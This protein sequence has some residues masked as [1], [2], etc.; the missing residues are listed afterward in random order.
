MNA[1][2][3]HFSSRRGKTYAWIDAA[4]PIPKPLPFGE[5]VRREAKRKKDEELGV[6]VD[7]VTKE[8]RKKRRRTAKS[9]K[10]DKKQE[11]GSNVETAIELD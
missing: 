7:D 9:K 8:P 10:A 6:S 4:K 1:T 5:Q 3:N 11:E 2:A